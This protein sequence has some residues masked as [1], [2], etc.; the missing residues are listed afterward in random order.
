MSKGVEGGAP[1]CMRESMWPLVFA[2]SL[3]PITPSP[4]R[5]PH[6]L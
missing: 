5:K 1:Y 6:M 2:L 4:I 3:A